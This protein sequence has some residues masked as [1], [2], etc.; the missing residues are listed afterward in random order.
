MEDDA[1]RSG[2]LGEGA[3][4]VVLGDLNADPED[5]DGRR[6]AVRALLAHPRVQ[7]PRPASP[8]GAA[9]AAAQG[10]ANATQRGDPALDTADWRDSGGPGNL[11]VDYALPSADLEVAGAGVFWPAPDG[12]LARLVTGGRRPA[13]SD[14]RLVWVDVR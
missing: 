8:G 11:R 7:D 4:F 1:G 3:S 10:G 5:G 14:H 6:E 2:A 12:P 13:S 9:A